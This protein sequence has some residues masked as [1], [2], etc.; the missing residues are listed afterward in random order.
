MENRAENF[1]YSWGNYALA[2]MFNQMGN[3]I[4]FQTIFQTIG[5]SRE[6]QMYEEIYYQYGVLIRLIFDFLPL[7]DGS[8]QSYIADFLDINMPNQSRAE[9]IALE[10]G[11]L[12]MVRVVND[13]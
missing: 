10:Q 11:L 12:K 5:E 7:E 2:F 13:F 8:L 9:R 3:A 1:D 4:S 6:N